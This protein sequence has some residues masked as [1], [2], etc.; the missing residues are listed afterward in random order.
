VVPVEGLLAVMG[1]GGGC[2]IIAAPK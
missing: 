1:D 2:P